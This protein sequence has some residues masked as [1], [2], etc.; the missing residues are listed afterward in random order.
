MRNFR[1]VNSSSLQ[2]CKAAV[3]LGHVVFIAKKKNMKTFI[4][5]IP[6]CFSVSGVQAETAAPAATSPAK[7]VTDLYSAHRGKPD[8]LQYPAS[9]KLLGAYFEAGLL[10]LFLKDQSE[11][12]GEVGKLDFDPLYAAQDFEIKDF[13]VGLV[14]Q[15]KHSAEVAASFKNMGKREKIGFLLSNT[16]QGWRITDIKYFDGRTLKGILNEASVPD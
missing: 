16:A 3:A 11:S 13:S 6:F 2:P 14:A 12:D 4:V 10:S 7:I 8:P 5:L 9:K 15:Q 1:A